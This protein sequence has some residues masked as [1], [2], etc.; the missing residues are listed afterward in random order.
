M[1]FFF[2]SML[3]RAFLT[4]YLSNRSVGRRILVCFSLFLPLQKKSSLMVRRNFNKIAPNTKNRLPIR[5]F[6]VVMG[7]KYLKKQKKYLPIKCEKYTMVRKRNST[8]SIFLDKS[9]VF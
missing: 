3:S 8:F 9:I 5:N 1:L 7:R 4:I 6:L 2:L